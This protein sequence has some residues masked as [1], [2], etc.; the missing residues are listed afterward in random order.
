M[1]INDDTDYPRLTPPDDRYPSPGNL[2]R[3]ADDLTDEQFDLL[4]A[5]WSE[6]ALP[7]DSL[8]EIEALF[9]SDPAKKAYAG[10]FRQL[11]LS[12][13]DDQWKGKNALLRTTPAVKII[14]RTYLVTLAAAA[15]AVVLL[16]LKPFAEKQPAIPAPVSSPDVT[17]VSEPTETA[18]LVVIKHIPEPVA[19]VT[20]TAVTS[21]KKELPAAEREQIIKITP[22]IVS[23]LTETPVITP[24]IDSRKLLAVKLNEIPSPVNIPEREENWIMK[25]IADLSRATKKEKTPVDGYTF[26]KS[27]INGINSV[28]GSEMALEKVI[29]KNGDTVGVTFSSSLLSFSAPVRKSSQ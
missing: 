23:A 12:P 14:L 15:V 26:A 13:C 19:A 29:G 24:G 20:K 3:S 4:A 18:P 8:A 9:A 16:T 21:E 1:A 11:R 5:A 28:F 10:N 17:V 27:C 6:N 22:V 2:F 7:D 25:G